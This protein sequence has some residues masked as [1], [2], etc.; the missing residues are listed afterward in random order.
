MCEYIFNEM[1]VILVVVLGV[2][3]PTAVVLLGFLA[4]WITGGPKI[5]EM[6]TSPDVM[7]S[8]GSEGGR[9]CLG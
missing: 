9:K 7:R 1:Q 2:L 4:Y 3:T 5:I 6:Y 8:D